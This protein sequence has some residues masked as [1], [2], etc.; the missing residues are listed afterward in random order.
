MHSAVMQNKKY[1]QFAEENTV[2]VLALQ[3]LDEAIQKEDRKAATYKKTDA[4]GVER[5]YMVEW[6][7][8]TAEMIANLSKSK[9]GQFNKTGRIPYTAIVN[10]WTEEEIKSWSG[11]Q[12]A[13]TIQ[14]AVMEARKA[15]FAEHGQGLSRQTITMVDEAIAEAQ[16]E[17]KDGD[18][19]K[20]LK[21]LEKV[22]KKSDEWPEVL[23]TK[24]A[25]A[26]TAVATAARAKIDEIK[27]LD[28]EV[29][30]K[31]ELRRV[32]SKLRGLDEL[33]NE[34]KELIKSL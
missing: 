34:V 1:V 7:S 20:A 6:P 9:A 23:K 18:F 25:E 32:S 19:A 31:R 24:H 30:M 8:L 21:A 10:P 13:K 11:G 28:N 15:L 2:E 33:E 29:E 12:S 14:E 5:D 27:G 3:R 4:D 16:T 26:V 17:A 22:S